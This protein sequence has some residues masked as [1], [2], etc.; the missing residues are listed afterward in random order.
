MNKV[1][2]WHRR[3]PGEGDKQVIT[4]GGLF[5]FSIIVT[6]VLKVLTVLNV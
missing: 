6:L 1:L 2:M 5:Y 4:E 3:I